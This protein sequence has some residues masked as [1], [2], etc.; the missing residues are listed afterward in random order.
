MAV[1]TTFGERLRE[2]RVAAGLSQ[3]ELAGEDLSASYISLI[4]SGKRMPS[5]AVIQQ[6]AARLGC[7]PS[8]LAEGKSSERDERIALEMAFA[9]LAV[10][11]GE[12]PEARRRLERLLG[13][14]GLPLRVRDEINVLVG[15]ACD[16][17]GDLQAAIKVLLP[18][19]ER[20]CIRQTHLLVHELGMSLSGCYQDAGDMV[21][22]VL[23]G[24]RALTAAR[25][26]GLTGTDEYYRL[27]ATVMAAYME[28][29]DYVHAR[30]W[31]EELL[32]QAQAEER[33]AGQAALYWN[34]GSLAEYEGRISDALA[35]CE[36]ALGR[37]SEL[38]S[39]RD[40][41]RLRLRLAMT[42]LLDDPPQ[43][44]RAVDLLERCLADL[45]DLGSRPEMAQWHCAMSVALLHRADLVNAEVRARQ[46][47]DLARESSPTLRAE[48]WQA[49]SDVLGAQG[50]D[51]SAAEALRTANGA[52]EEVSLA[53]PVA[54]S[55]RELAER[56]A[57]DDPVAAMDAFRRALDAAE[58][59]DRG[60]AHRAQAEALRARPTVPATTG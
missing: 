4:E 8:R 11:H 57:A 40:F 50:R 2:L 6:L 19:F 56:L 13:E 12:A 33:P 41:A 3:T 29:G 37:L 55:W 32:V 54:L 27:A 10:E 21:Q 20:A 22:A 16:R 44:D 36:R 43:V 1:V 39:S 47:V 48:A 9:R 35:L 5:D 34:L 24:E 42:L 14:D 7:S 30:I 28:R 31:A 25:D 26:Q 23:V 15:L 45:T 51:D 58:V 46:A 59:R 53:R 38:D 18:L 52:L 60:R 49:L 17:S